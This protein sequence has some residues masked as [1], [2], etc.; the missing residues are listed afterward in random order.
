MRKHKPLL[1]LF[2]LLILFIN[3][4]SQNEPVPNVL[5]Q[6]ISVRYPHIKIDSFLD[7][8]HHEFGFDFSYD[9]S[10]FNKDSIIQATYSNQ[11]LEYILNE[12]F[13]NYNPVF[14][15]I[16]QQ[17]IIS[18]KHR[19]TIVEDY[20]TLSGTIT[21]A[22][23]DKTLPLVNISIKGL[24]LGTTSN[25]EGRFSFLIPKKYLG[26]Q[27]YFSSLG[28]QSKFIPV[29]EAD[30]SLHIRLEE[31]TI[32]LKEIE[33]KYMKAT[34]IIMQTIANIEQNYSTH[35]LLLTAF[36]RESIK[37]DGA[38]IEV[39]EAILDI[40][41]SSYQLT[42]DIEKV[43]FIKGR[44]MV[45][46]KDIAVARLKLAGGPS[47]F[48]AIDVTK[49]R[50]FLNPKLFFYHYKGKEIEFDRVVYKVGFKP[51]IE[52]E[53]IN[54]EGELKIDIESFALIS[55][56]FSM[57]KKTLRNSSKYLIRKNAKKVKSIP[58]YTQYYVDYRPYKDKWIL[59]NVR[60]EIK[61]KM[62][63][64]RNK[65]KSI[66]S[67]TAEMLIT[68]A[69]NG[70]GQKIRYSEA[71]K[72]NYILADHITNY[73]PDFW[74]NYN[75]IRPEEELEKVFKS[76]AIEINVVPQIKNTRP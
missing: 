42:D 8:L 2:I 45:E 67:A 20:I 27:V 70:K 36:F 51:I 33:V 59:N 10:G 22:E 6:K 35:P 56:S 7:S 23:N 44:K 75:V 15:A 63:D 13:S 55:A 32:R 31:E 60:G 40:Y 4:W 62:L 1:S 41:K 29:P 66:Y 24:P 17:V 30:S 71:Y 25:M 68:D 69:I 26:K 46:D 9:P 11:S 28:Y 19:K 53:D 54:Y 21:S 14:Q 74:K 73:D 76:K 57:T 37:Q 64:K 3:G 65:T 39:S 48:S 47:L 38:Y 49:H 34:D 50:D 16:Q 58:I 12:I 72:Q 18:F 43:K 52:S 61:I 5:S